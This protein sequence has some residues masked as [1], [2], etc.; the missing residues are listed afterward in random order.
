MRNGGLDATFALL[1][2]TFALGE[3]RPV[4][5]TRPHIFNGA[6]GRHSRPLQGQI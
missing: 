3:N 4:Y 6:E 5:L 1:E 2:Q